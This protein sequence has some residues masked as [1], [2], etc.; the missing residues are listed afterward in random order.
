MNTSPW[1]RPR[2][3]TPLVLSH[4]KSWFTAIIPPGHRLPDPV[5]LAKITGLEETGERD[6]SGDAGRDG[7]GRKC[8]EGDFGRFYHGWGQAR[9]EGVRVREED[10]REER[11][12][13]G[14]ERV[15]DSDDDIDESPQVCHEFCLLFGTM[16]SVV[17]AEKTAKL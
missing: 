7:Q 14:G 1:R 17:D 3:S 12:V 6:R 15:L 11:I 2:T 16:T 8:G 9:F 5:E 10:I 4:N 13:L